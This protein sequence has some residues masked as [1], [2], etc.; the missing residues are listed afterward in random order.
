MSL[1]LSSVDDKRK[2]RLCRAIH[3]LN[4]GNSDYQEL[5]TWIAETLETMRRKS[6]S[7]TDFTELRMNQGRCQVLQSLFDV[8]KEAAEVIRRQ[9]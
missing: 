1:S 7:I 2:I 3:G 5:L 9:T 8:H 4:R 6:D